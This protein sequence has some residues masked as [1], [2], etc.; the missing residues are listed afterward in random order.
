MPDDKF[1]DYYIIM[2]EKFLPGKASFIVLSETQELV[3]IKQKNANLQVL[4]RNDEA[5]KK[6]IKNISQTHVVVFHSFQITWAPLIYAIPSQ[7]KRVWLFWGYEGYDTIPKANFLDWKSNY[8]MYS[9]SLMGALRFSYNRLKVNFILKRNDEARK[10]ISKMDYCATWVDADYLFAKKFNPHLKFLQFNYYTKE[11][12]NFEEI[13]VQAINHN[14]ILLGNSGASTNNH[15]EALQYLHKIKYGGEIFCP[16]SY[17]ASENYLMNVCL[18]G[19]KLFG[20]RFI[21]LKNFMPLNEYQEIINSCG[22]IWMNHKRQQAAGNLLFL[23]MAQKIIITDGRSPLNITFKKWGL[24]FFNREILKNLTA[25]SEKDLER[26][27][28]IILERITINENEPF[29]NALND[30]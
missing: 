25:V 13:P 8:A 2:S 17:N 27:R 18:F 11:L 15:I 1:L 23:F 4:I 20:S 28:Q 29:F 9:K 21:P 30:M 10:I 3:H 6:L 24:N 22:V 16:L 5:Y 14:R 19:D 12:M 26:N 7:I